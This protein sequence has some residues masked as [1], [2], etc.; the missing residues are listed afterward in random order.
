MGPYRVWASPAF[1][2]PLNILKEV[3]TNKGNKGKEVYI[4]NIKLSL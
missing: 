3:E 1:A 4:I 2:F